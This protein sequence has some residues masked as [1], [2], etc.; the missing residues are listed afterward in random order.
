MGNAISGDGP[1]SGH[2]ALLDDNAC[3]DIQNSAI[4]NDAYVAE[5]FEGL[6]VYPGTEIKKEVDMLLIYIPL[7]I[8]LFH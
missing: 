6:P 1:S 8:Y 5:V 7:Y 3:L 4:F 2:V